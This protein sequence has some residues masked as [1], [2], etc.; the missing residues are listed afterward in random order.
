MPGWAW[1]LLGL[2]S[3]SPLMLLMLALAHAAGRNRRH[4]GYI[5]PPASAGTSPL[6]GS[7]PPTSTSLRPPPGGV[8]VAWSLPRAHRDPSRLT[9]RGWSGDLTAARG[10]NGEPPDCAA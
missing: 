4:G 3:A 5:R 7:F 8:S 6:T 1:Y 9:G 2:F 10:V